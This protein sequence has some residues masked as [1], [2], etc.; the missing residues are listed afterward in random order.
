MVHF[1]TS[2]VV[3]PRCLRIREAH[4]LHL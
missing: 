3:M 1:I 4:C 2:L